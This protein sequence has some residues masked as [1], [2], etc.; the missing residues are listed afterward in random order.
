MDFESLYSRSARGL[1]PS[2]IRALLKL[3]QRSEIISFAGGTPD[4]ALFPLETFAELSRKVV[5]EQ[6]RMALQYGETQGWKPLREQVAAYLSAKGIAAD[7]EGI[8]ITGGSQ[9]AID[10]LARVLLDEGDL[11]AMEDPGYL[12]ALYA[13]R[14]HG[15][16]ITPL[17]MDSDGL[18]PAA[19]SAALAPSTGSGPP[20]PKPPK[21]LYLTP[22]FQNPSGRLLSAERRREIAALSAAKELLVIEDDPYGE[23]DF[24]GNAPKPLAS[25][26]KAGNIVFLGTFSKI[27]VPGLRL[28]WAC[29]PKEL[30]NKMVL[31]KETADVSSGVFAQA[32][33]S[34]F[35]KAGYLGPHLEKLRATY[36]SRAMAMA[37]ALKASGAPLKF[38]DPKG[39][40]FIWADL[41]KGEGGQALFDRAL[42]AG[43]AYVPGTAFFARPSD[44][45]KTLRLTFC[46]VNEEKIAEGV[47]RLA[48]VLNSGMPAEA[49]AKAG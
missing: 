4:S 8:I 40:F 31:A 39:G 45:E 33:A 11:V 29:G 49:S 41:L 34:E 46:A 14:A 1:K 47:K 44:G 27:G 5:L 3:V 38:E 2:I 32:V 12:G 26:D 10:L 16:G 36:K 25:H 48:G 19:L 28:G 42:A 43:V 20:A 17:P 24:T 18:I 23:I 21:F 13:F 22:T 6:G 37:A 30:I 15:A 35:L 7:P 9:Q